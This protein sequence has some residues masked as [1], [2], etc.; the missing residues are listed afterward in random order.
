VERSKE[1]DVSATLTNPVRTRIL[2][3]DDDE[4]L[5]RLLAL[6]F[7]S[8]GFEA[9]VAKDGVTTLAEAATK[10]PDAILLDVHMPEVDG[11]TVLR[12]LR[13]D[14]RTRQIP[15]VLMSGGITPPE[16]VRPA[17]WPELFLRKP[18]PLAMALQSVRRLVDPSVVTSA[19]PA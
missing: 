19:V 16:V 2:I 14:Q 1:T 5:G 6:V 3:A 9:L 18:F 11:W 10:R 12:R 7:G 17:E 15:V 4:F 8:A 13:A